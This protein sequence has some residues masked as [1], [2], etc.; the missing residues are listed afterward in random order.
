MKAPHKIVEHMA[1]HIL[2]D[3]NPP[4]D[5]DDD[6]CGFCLSTGGHCSLRLLKRKGKDGSQR[7]D[8]EQSRCPNVANLGLGNAGK[9]SEN[10][11]CTNVPVHCPLLNCADVVWTY[12]LKSHIQR[13]H[14]GANVVAYKSYYDKHPSEKV[15]LKRIS[16]TKT[17]TRGKKAI[18]FRIS[19]QHSTQSALG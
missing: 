3:T 14:P 8:L 17:R 13:I 15:G 11:P 7:I 2:F 1:I 9:F 5:P 16:K 4:I 10:R 12:N 6:V 18:T 19:E